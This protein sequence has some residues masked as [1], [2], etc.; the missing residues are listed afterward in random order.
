M[1]TSAAKKSRKLKQQSYQSF[2]LSKKIKPTHAALPS[3]WRLFRSSVTTLRQHQRFFAGIALVYGLLFLV[4]VRGVA[5]LDVGGSKD[6]LHDTL[7]ENASNWTV[8]MTIFT[9][10][11]SGSWAENTDLTSLYQLIIVIICSLALIWG[12]RQAHTKGVKTLRVKTAFYRGMYPLVPVLLVLGMILLQLVPL[13]LAST[14]YAAT[15][16]NGIATTGVEQI[17]WTL[18]C[19]LLVVLSLFFVSSSLFALYIVTLPNMEPMQALRSARKLVHHRRLVV[20]RKLL[21][22][23]I[24]LFVL[25]GLV[26]IPLI[27]FLPILAE[28]VF[29]GLSILMLPIV[30][31]YIY[32]L[33]RELL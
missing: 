13:A 27:A 21:W 28:L 33:Y 16:V 29:F 4:F 6:I 30:H 8:S 15:V 2:R 17:L 25:L 7:G 31:A 32:T 18:L 3:A 20:A 26:V 22:L 11:A 14:L 12:L 23:P 1:K 9:T 24:A 10:M 19:L 5:G